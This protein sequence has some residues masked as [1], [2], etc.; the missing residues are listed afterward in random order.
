[1]ERRIALL[2]LSQGMPG[3]RLLGNYFDTGRV[4]LH[5]PMPMSSSYVLITKNAEVIHG[6]CY[7]DITLESA[8]DCLV[9]LSATVWALGYMT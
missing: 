8:V 7:H 3:K 5:Q 4:Q 2:K 1:M 9:K 6:C